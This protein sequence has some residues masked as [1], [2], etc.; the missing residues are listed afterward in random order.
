MATFTVIPSAEQRA[1]ENRNQ[2]PSAIELD[3]HNN[4]L[5]GK[6]VRLNQIQKPNITEP[7]R[8]NHL[9]LRKTKCIMCNEGGP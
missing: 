2:K 4:Y 9:L 5:L 1:W 6:R 7:D 3:I 8:T